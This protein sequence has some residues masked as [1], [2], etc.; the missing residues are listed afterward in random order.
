MAR[1]FGY[2]LRRLRETRRLTQ[3]ALARSTGLNVGFVNRLESGERRPTSRKVVDTLLVALGADP[4]ERATLFAAAGFLPDDVE[5][6]GV[7]DPSILLVSRMLN[8]DRIPS[9]A[10]RAVRQALDALGALV[11]SLPMANAGVPTV[12]P[13]HREGDRSEEER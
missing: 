2:N 7:D 3:S 5:R 1:D 6:V 4:A 12:D 8:P 9:E 13:A 10:R 11:A